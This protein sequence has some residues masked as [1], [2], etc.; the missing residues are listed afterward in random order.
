MILP[1]KFIGLL[2]IFGGAGGGGPRFRTGGV[3]W[4]GGVT[5]TQPTPCDHV[6]GNTEVLSASSL[7]FAMLTI[8]K[9]I[10]VQKETQSH[11][12]CYIQPGPWQCVLLLIPRSFLDGGAVNY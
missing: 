10:T 3:I 1:S 5:N 12:A 4:G 8:G 7:K 11:I 2:K 9:K 6:C